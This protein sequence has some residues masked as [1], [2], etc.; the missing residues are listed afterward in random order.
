MALT[1]QK[2][3]CLHDDDGQLSQHDLVASGQNGPC[4]GREIP[5]AHAQF[6][7]WGPQTQT[8]SNL[9]I[10]IF[11]KD[12]ISHSHFLVLTYIAMFYFIPNYFLFATQSFFSD[13]PR[14]DETFNCLATRG[15]GQVS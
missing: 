7:T 13:Y 1:D 8:V 6:N 11:K 4:F 9:A 15:R 14:S 3:N 10:D 5:F 2:Q 12:L